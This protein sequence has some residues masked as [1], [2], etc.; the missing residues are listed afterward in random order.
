MV[1]EIQL[2][3]EDLEGELLNPCQVVVTRLWTGDADSAYDLAEKVEEVVQDFKSLLL[4]S[5]KTLCIV[6]NPWHNP[7]RLDVEGKPK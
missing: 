1:A 3:M 6:E 4:Y 5:Y 2:P 7:L